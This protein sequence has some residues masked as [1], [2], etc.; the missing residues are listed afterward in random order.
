M[1]LML[2]G[3]PATEI[4]AADPQVLVEEL[5]LREAGFL[6]FLMEGGDN[7]DRI[8]PG[9]S[10]AIMRCSDGFPPSA[11]A[12]PSRIAISRRGCR[13]SRRS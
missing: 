10:M 7:G 3:Q 12:T 13:A 1:I 6:Q 5:S 9:A 2:S 8:E 4:V 11:G